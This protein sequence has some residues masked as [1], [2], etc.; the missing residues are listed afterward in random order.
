MSQ[1]PDSNQEPLQS[2]P[3]KF[4]KRLGWAV[5]VA[6]IVFAGLT[7]LILRG[8]GSSNAS[9]PAVQDSPFK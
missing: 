9:Q 2:E 6:L 1:S 7:A 3:S 5:L 8:E 4:G